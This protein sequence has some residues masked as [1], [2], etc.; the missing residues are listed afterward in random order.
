MD[1]PDMILNN[2]NYKDML[3]KYYQNLN[4]EPPTYEEISQKGPPHNRIFTVC[5]RDE[6]SDIISEGIGKTKKKAD[7]TAAYNALVKLGVLE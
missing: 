5:V 2:N 4:K 1:F 6:N 3:M 7:K